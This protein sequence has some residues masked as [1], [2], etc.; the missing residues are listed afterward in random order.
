V[1]TN[2]R[3]AI[4]WSAVLLG[5]MVF[6]F[7]AVGR[8][9]PSSAPTT[10]LPFVGEFDLSVYHWM[11]DI[12]NEVLTL[13]ARFLNVL[14]SGLVTIPLRI[15]VT[16]WL[17][18]RKRW[19]ALAT[20]VITWAAAE[21]T[22]AGA[23]TFFH[24]GRPPLPL[25]DVV[26]FSFP[27]GHAVAGAATAVALVLVLLPPGPARR[28]WELGAI[29]FAFVMAM[30]RVYLNAHWFSDVVAGVLLGAGIALGSAGVVTEI[31]DVALR[32]RSHA[33]AAG[34]SQGAPLVLESPTD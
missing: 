30:S 7:A 28:R 11:D 8:H 34:H 23:K 1:L 5:A 13:L 31:R 27:S 15:A 2:H 29:A 25:V 16:A 4:V 19:R 12:R 22:L 24:R 14:G 20:W 21:L 33:A 9:P 32:R 17:L 26:G 18:I 6:V 10:T 3:R